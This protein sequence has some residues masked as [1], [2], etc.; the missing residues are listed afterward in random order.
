MKIEPTCSL[1]LISLLGF[2]KLYFFKLFCNL[3]F[4]YF[5][6]QKPFQTSRQWKRFLRKRRII[7][8]DGMANLSLET[9]IAKANCWNFFVVLFISFAFLLSIFVISIQIVFVTSQQSF[10][11]HSFWRSKTTKTCLQKMKTKN[12]YVPCWMQ[13]CH[14][15]FSY[16][17]VSLSTLGL[18]SY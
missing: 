3:Y 6:L 10:L 2:L 17:D 16:N 8:K 9:Q 12:R 14:H 4:I 11:L 7:N 13:K 18:L 5:L 15:L 1:K